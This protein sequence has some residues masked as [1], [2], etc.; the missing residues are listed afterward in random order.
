MDKSS[1]AANIFNKLANLY[2][3]KFMDTSLYH[4]SF[5]I[6]CDL[7]KKE[8]PE[9]L[10]LAC[11]PGNISKYILDHYP[12]IQFLG[13]DLA[14]NMIELARKNNPN[15][16]F[17]V[18]DCRDVVSLN[19]KFDA[20][21]CGFILPYLSRSEVQKLLYDLFTC[22]NS[23]GVLYI[24]TMEDDY[25]KSD[26][27]KG[28]TGDEIFMHFYLGSD[29]EQYIFNAGFV[30]HRVLRKYQVDNSGECVTD[31]ILIALKK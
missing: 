21:L 10:E 7:I 11:G 25:I 4:E 8:N 15:G 17:M 28:S 5:D 18:M 14:P 26:Y 9:I 27:K 1:H 19:K 23:Q 16:N 20:V 31:V 2:E 24:S 3:Q 29:L 13:T 12:H 22:I 6:F 30:I